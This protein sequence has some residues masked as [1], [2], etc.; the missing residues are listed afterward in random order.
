MDEA[1]GELVCSSCGF[2]ACTIPYR[3]PEWRA[4]G[5]ADRLRRERAGAPLTPLIH[6]LGLST[7]PPAGYSSVDRG[8]DEV[9]AVLSEIYRLSTSMGLPRS[10]AETAALYLRRLESRLPR[11]RG[12]EGLLPAALLHLALRIH[13][14]PIGVRELASLSGID[15]KALRSLS[16]RLAGMLDLKHLENVEACISKLVRALDLPGVVEERANRLC[17]SAIEAGLSQGRSRRALAAAALYHAA[18]SLG[19]RISQ[20]RLAELAG[21]GLT[22]LRRRLRELAHLAPGEEAR[23]DTMHI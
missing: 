6:D 12:R 4:Y 10:V 1:S 9:I 11:A 5:D 18:R 15:P 17:A 16:M 2:V 8:G 20:R 3:G 7:R 21:V 22:T 19:Y 23:S 13:G 14:I